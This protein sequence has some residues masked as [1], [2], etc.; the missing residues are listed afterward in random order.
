MFPV[1]G[2]PSAGPADIATTTPTLGGDK[3]CKANPL[4]ADMGYVRRP[5]SASARM[6]MGSRRNRLNIHQASA[7][8]EHFLQFHQAAAAGRMKPLWAASQVELVGDEV[9]WRTVMRE[10]HD[11]SVGITVLDVRAHGL[12]WLSAATH[13]P[14]PLARGYVEA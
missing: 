11:L 10:E 12:H 3:K 6:P 14:K 7:P 2:T 8:K 5:V 4:L 13:S 9:D 1:G